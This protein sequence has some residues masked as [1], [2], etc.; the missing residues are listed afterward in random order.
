MVSTILRL[1]GDRVAVVLPVYIASDSALVGW[2]IPANVRLV[3]QMTKQANAVHCI[4]AHLSSTGVALG[5]V[6]GS[7]VHRVCVCV[8]SVLV[9][10]PEGWSAARA[11][12]MECAPLL[13]PTQERKGAREREAQIQ[14][15]ESVETWCNSVKSS[16]MS[17]LVFLIPPQSIR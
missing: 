1:G 12:D 7:C 3:W 13:L 8:A 6:F 11:R 17:A 15:T 10:L 16:R 4:P 2:Q 9:C 5:W 14:L